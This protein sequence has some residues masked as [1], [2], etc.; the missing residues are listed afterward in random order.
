LPNTVIDL[1]KNRELK[2]GMLV[3]TIII[4][5]I[6]FRCY[7]FLTKTELPLYEVQ[8]GTIYT[9]SQAKGMILREELLVTTEI[10]GYINYYYSE[11]SR[12]SKNSTVYSID[13]DRNI[14]DKLAGNPSE[15]KLSGEKLQ[16]LKTLLQHTLINAP[17]KDITKIKTTIIGSYQRM[18][19]ETLSE[20]LMEIV[21]Q[22]GISSNFHVISSKASGIISYVQDPY[23]GYDVQDVSKYCFTEAYSSESL[24]R[25]DLISANSSIYKVITNDNWKIVVLLD[26]VLYG[27]LLGSDT[28]TF[29]LNDTLKVTAPISCYRKEDSYFAAISMDKYLSN[30]SSERFLNV[31]FEL[32]ETEGLKIPETAITQKDFYRIPEQY[33][34]LGGNAEEETLSKGL[35]VEE[36]NKETGVP[37]Y[38]FHAIEQF[39]TE[40]GFVYIDYESFP[41]ET[42]IYNRDTGARIMLYTFTSKLEGVYNINKGYAVFKRIERIKTDNGYVIIK[43]GS[44]SGL[45]AY[46][47]IALDAAKAV[48]DGI[49]Y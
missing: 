26:D 38:K 8:P 37:E 5:Y 34:V 45:S 30:F 42:Y 24:Y 33:V 35:L 16:Q 10:A 15:I 32:E 25:T 36:F 19:D 23:T 9:T 14:Y 48:E 13:S 46:D 22:T 11:G 21:T 3:A 47:H 7:T 49:I 1:N 31:K 28:A 4:I 18:I 40:N 29:Y 27:A 43:K 20:Q 17:S 6:L 41:S 39:Y 2:I 44:I 12:I